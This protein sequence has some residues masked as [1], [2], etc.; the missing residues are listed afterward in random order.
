MTPLVL[1]QPDD[2]GDEKLAE[3]EAAAEREQGEQIA[4]AVR[5]VELPITEYLEWPWPRLARTMG[6]MAPGTL[7]FLCAASG[8]GKTSFL[9]SAARRWC[10]S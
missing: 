6:G 5:T 10:S 8:A 2:P 7:G 4:D 9:M 3:R 1:I